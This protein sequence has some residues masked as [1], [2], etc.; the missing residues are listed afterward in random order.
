VSALGGDSK[1]NSYIWTT[2]KINVLVN[3]INTGRQDIRKLSRSPFKDNDINLKRE[4]L[5]FEYTP[6]EMDELAKCKK[7][8]MYFVLNYCVIRTFQGD[9][10]IRE[11]GGLRD[12]QNQILANF[13]DNNL[14]ILMASRQTGKCL[15]LNTLV[16]LY[17]TTL[18]IKVTLPLYELY[19]MLIKE[20]RKLTI[21]EKIKYKLYKIAYYCQE[22][23]D[24]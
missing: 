13:K 19:F 5:P 24:K 7:S 17:D 12:F 3:D 21:F 15:T 1:D 16:E 11:L 6:E 8:L 14:N 9:K 10:L 2:E 20:S 22:A 18:N 4:D 23:I